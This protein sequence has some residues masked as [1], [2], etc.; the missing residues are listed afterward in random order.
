MTLRKT[1][2]IFGLML[3]LNLKPGEAKRKMIF[4][5]VTQAAQRKK[6]VYPQQESNLSVPDPDLEITGGGGG[7]GV[8]QK[9]KFGPQFGLKLSGAGPPDPSPGSATAY[10]LLVTSPDTLALNSSTEL[11]ENHRSCFQVSASTPPNLK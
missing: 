10:D 3:I 2:E 7:G 9:K 6:T 4:Q 8:A 11:Q 1:E 5:S